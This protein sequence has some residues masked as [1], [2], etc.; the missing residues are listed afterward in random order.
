MTP[1]TAEKLTISNGP[2]VL[3]P[4]EFCVQGNEALA[5]QIIFRCPLRRA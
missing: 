5:L 4:A 2:V 3:L 1:W